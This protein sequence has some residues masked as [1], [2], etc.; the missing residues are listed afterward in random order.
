MRDGI[1]AA[2]EIAY[3]MEGDGFPGVVPGSATYEVKLLEYIKYLRKRVAPIY[4]E[5]EP[6]Q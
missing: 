3:L 1:N 2:I 4:Y 5:R 6:L